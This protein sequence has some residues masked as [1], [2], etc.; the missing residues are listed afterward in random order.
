MNRED[1]PALQPDRLLA[2]TRWASHWSC[3]GRQPARTQKKRR[4]GARRW[5]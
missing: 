3:H 4:A 2:L 1:L 5:L